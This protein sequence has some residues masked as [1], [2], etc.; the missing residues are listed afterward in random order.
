MTD[1]IIGLDSPFYTDPEVREKIHRRL[2]KIAIYR[3]QNLGST[4]TPEEWQAFKEWEIKQLKAVQKYDTA[5]IKRL[6]K[7]EI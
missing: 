4:S 6:L 7:A 2:H 1:P 3:A 5:Y